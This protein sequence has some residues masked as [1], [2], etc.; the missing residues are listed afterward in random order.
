MNAVVGAP[1]KRYI[2]FT[3]RAGF[4]GFVPMKIN[5]QIKVNLDVAKTIGAVTSFIL[6]LYL[7]LG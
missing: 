1:A 2:R 3:G 7:I 6:V 5:L 4:G